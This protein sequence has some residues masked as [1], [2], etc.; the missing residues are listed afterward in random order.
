MNIPGDRILELEIA[1]P[2]LY[3]IRV[4]IDN[5]EYRLSEIRDIRR[6]PRV[7]AIIIFDGFLYG[8]PGIYGGYGYGI[9]PG[10]SYRPQ[11]FRGGELVESGKT[12]IYPAQV[13]CPPFPPGPPPP[14]F[15]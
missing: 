8:T 11:F 3:C 2:Q 10:Y 5:E 13:G 12:F 1:Q 7:D 15:L 9:I 4:V 14:P 6:Y